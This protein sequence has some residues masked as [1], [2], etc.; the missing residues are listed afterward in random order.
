MVWIGVVGR[1]LDSPFYWAD[2]RT[3][4]STTAGG[5][6]SPYGYRPQQYSV[7]SGRIAHTLEWSAMTF[8]TA[9]S[10]GPDGGAHLACR[11]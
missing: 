7:A 8:D 6:A 1:V 4:Y 5:L 11:S 10:S 2:P 9:C 3:W